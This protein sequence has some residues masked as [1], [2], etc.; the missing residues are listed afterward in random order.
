M[1]IDHRSSSERKANRRYSYSG[2]DF[3]IWAYYPITE[4]KSSNITNLSDDVPVRDFFNPSPTPAYDLESL[5]IVRD[6]TVGLEEYTR[7]VAEWGNA[8]VEFHGIR[9]DSSSDGIVPFGNMQTITSSFASSLSAVENIGSSL[10]VSHTRGQKTFAGSMIFTVLDKEPLKEMIDNSF[11]S[12]RNDKDQRAE[13]FTIDQIPAFNVVI[14][15]SNELPT[16]NGLPQQILKVLVGV[17]IMTHG[18]TISI[19]DF[20]LEQTYQY[21]CR[22]VSPWI[23]TVDSESGTLASVTKLQDLAKV[24]ANRSWRIQ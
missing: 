14:Q 10:P 2:A 13:Y 6:K 17:K 18:E 7:L 16:K 8:L 22:Y 24:Q 5:E 12:Q 11:L 4:V 20:F 1:N 3:N 23:T 9:V 15:G 19:D 21:V